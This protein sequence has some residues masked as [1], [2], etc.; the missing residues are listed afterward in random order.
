M[1]HPQPFCKHI[2]PTQI[3]TLLC[4]MMSPFLQHRYFSWRCYH[5][6]HWSS[7]D[8]SAYAFSIWSKL[9]IFLI[10]VKVSLFHIYMW[11][12]DYMTFSHVYMTMWLYVYDY[13]RIWLYIS[14]SHTHIWSFCLPFF[15]KISS[16][17][18]SIYKLGKACLW[19]ILVKIP[20]TYPCFLD[21]KL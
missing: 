2:L 14:Y 11:I 5:L 16:I 19:F 10:A 6:L 15:L 17:Y 21:L 20:T 4:I 18:I 7:N 13:V 9:S 3:S 8:T 1:W 12:Y